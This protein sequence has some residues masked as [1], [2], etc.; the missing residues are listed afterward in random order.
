MHCVDGVEKIE[1]Y[2]DDYRDEVCVEEF[3]S[4]TIDKEGNKVDRITAY[5]KKNLWENC[6]GTLTQS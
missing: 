3:T 6:F 2:C 5:C 1:S 4:L